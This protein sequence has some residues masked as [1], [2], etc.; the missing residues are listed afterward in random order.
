MVHRRGRKRDAPTEEV[1]GKE[2]I[3]RK[4]NL[5]RLLFNGLFHLSIAFG[6]ADADWPNCPLGGPEIIRVTQKEERVT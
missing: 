6:I 4:N 1:R 5:M 3:G 2:N